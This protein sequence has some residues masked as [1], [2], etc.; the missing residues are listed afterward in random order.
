[1]RL[2]ILFDAPYWV[3]L[4]EVEQ[5]GYLYAARHIFGAEPGDQEVYDFVQRDLMALQ[6][7]MTVGTR[8]GM[9][10]ENS[11][12]RTTNYNRSQR[13]VRRQLSQQVVVSKAQE[14]LRLQIEQDKRERKQNRREEREAR[15]AHHRETTIA[16]AKARHRG[17]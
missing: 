10:A 7:R 11:E 15:R 3:A 14:A 12:N 13:E 16:K 5:D 2:T 8:V 17:R 4:L 6:A 1:M 9:A